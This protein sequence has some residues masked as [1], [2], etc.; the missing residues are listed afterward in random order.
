MA[1]CYFMFSVTDCEETLRVFPACHMSTYFLPYSV[2]SDFPLKP[3][4]KKLKWF[5]GF[6]NH[7]SLLFIYFVFKGLST[8]WLASVRKPDVHSASL[9]T[10]HFFNFTSHH[11]HEQWPWLIRILY[12]KHLAWCLSSDRWPNMYL[13]VFRTIVVGIIC[14]CHKYSGQLVINS[15][16]SHSFLYT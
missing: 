15:W 16:Q 7:I 11:L 3:L 12:T 6:K 4:R 5:L 10:T 8:T 14:A 1:S 13:L 2:A 9:V